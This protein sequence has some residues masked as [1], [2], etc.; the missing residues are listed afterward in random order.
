MRQD[1]VRAACVASSAP[2]AA[3]RGETGN[4]MKNCLGSTFWAAG[5]LVLAAAAAC[6]SSEADPALS[7]ASSSPPTASS[8]IASPTSSSDSAGADASAT[9]GS[10]F[11]VLD[12]LRTKPSTDLKQLSSVATTT[13]L[14]AAQTLVRAQ[15]DRGQEQVGN[16]RIVELTVQSVNL[17][18]SDP[19]SG[20]V[21]T[22]VIDVC[23]DVTD[24]DVLDKDGKSI[25]AADRPDTGWTRYTVAN[26][27][28]AAD[29]T[30]G[31]RVA[32]GQDLKETPC[33]P[34]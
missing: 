26:Y 8:T 20:K 7:T 21:P 14:N 9:I 29:P 13:Q 2:R 6:G 33:A 18:N 5:A 27:N 12:K 19:A 4:R 23:W 31:W 3:R 24:V 11:Q 16:T 10:Y 1:D 30:G 32:N 15:R 34:S 22:V 17:D 25:V 28:Y